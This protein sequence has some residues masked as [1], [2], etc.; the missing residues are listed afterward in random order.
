[1]DRISEI[2]LQ[3]KTLSSEARNFEE[4]EANW[5]QMIRSIVDYDSL[6][7]QALNVGFDVF[8]VRTGGDLIR[9]RAN[10]HQFHAFLGC[11]QSFYDGFLLGTQFQ[12][13]G[14]HRD[15]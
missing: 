9:L 2:V 10:Q 8:G 3:L 5:D 15:A 13:R 1:M 14:G 12:Q 6:A 11:I 7:W 4:H